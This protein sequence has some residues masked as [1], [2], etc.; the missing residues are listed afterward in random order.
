MGC[1]YV[2]NKIEI[3]SDGSPWR[4]IVHVLDLCNAILAILV[5]PAK[6]INNEA[7]NVGIE[8]G[9]YTVKDIA[10]VAQSAVPNSKLVFL[11]QH[12]DPRSYRVSFK[13]ITSRLK[14]YYS[15]EWTLEK[16]ASEMIEFFNEISFNADMFNGRQTNR[17]KQIH[18][19]I[20][21]QKIDSN[22]EKNK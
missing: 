6:I 21:K 22:L 12:T 9:N 17:L 10:I 7:F 16:G 5:A 19:L 11:N 20:S 2:K 18:Y 4:P 1:A 13:K 8:N 14:G 3:L 15:P